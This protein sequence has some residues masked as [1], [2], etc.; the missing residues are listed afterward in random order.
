MKVYFTCFALLAAIVIFTEAAPLAHESHG[1]SDSKCPLMVKVLD[2]VR[3]SPAENLA[4]KLFR[5]EK[6][7]SWEL[8]FTGK[9]SEEGEIHDVITEENFVQGVYKV[10]FDTKP[11]WKLFG[12]NPF[13]EF[14]DVV[15]SANNAGHR[16][17]TIAVLLTPFSFSTTAVVSDIISN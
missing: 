16:H 3:G 6:D 9:T 10:E 8:L 1:V 2:A 12:L 11:F 7:G 17:Y 13:H 14:A 15:F 5:K 4:V